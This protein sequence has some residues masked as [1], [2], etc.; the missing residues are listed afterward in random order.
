MWLLEGDALQ[1]YESERGS[2]RHYLKLLLRRFV[3]HQE[4][5]LQRL[6][7]GGG[8]KIIPLEG[9]GAEADAFIPDPRVLDPDKV[10]ER[11]WLGEV[12]NQSLERV[13]ERCLSGPRAVAF[14]VY[15]E[16]E[17][18]AEATRPT[19]AE[20]AKRFGLTEGQITAQLHAI[21]GEIRADI[22]R[23][24]AR[25]TSDDQELAREWNDLF[26]G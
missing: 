14:K 18:T 12:V 11:A 13:R 10:F 23:E 22:R 21:R 9:F 8:F 17:L 5:A 20:L 26:G 4:E 15:E 6:K 16:Y 2:F 19:Y 25:L 3:V 7:R 24:L 1:R